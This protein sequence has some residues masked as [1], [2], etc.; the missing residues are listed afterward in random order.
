MGTG[1]GLW[2][3]EMIFID[4]DA[5]P[6]KS[7]MKKLTDQP[8]SRRKFIQ[9]SGALFGASL[10]MQHY[11]GKVMAE[12]VSAH[13]IKVNAHLWVYASKYPPKWDSTPDLESVFSDMH[14]AGIDGVE[15]MDINLRHDNA[16][17]NLSTL[18]QKYHLPVSGT[19]YG[20]NMWDRNEHKAILEDV[21]IIVTRLHQLK[22]KTFGISVGDARHLKT[23]DELDAQASLLKQIIAICND[24]GIEANLHNHTYEVENAMHDLKGTLARIPGIKLGPD[25]NWLIRAGINPVDFINTY[26]NQMVYMHLRDQYADG[27]WTEYLSQGVTDFTAIAQALKA[28]NF[29]GNAAIELA[30]PAGFTPVNPLKE[31]WKKS[32]DYVRHVFGW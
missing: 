30:F 29:K 27:S 15:L 6:F 26:G 5:S 23:E 4:N 31:D 22:G 25:L 21:T 7:H 11:F 8:S 3:Y 19:S 12:A 17:Q 10:L 28:Q 2:P 18:I 16:V 14:Y 24:N 13:K 9:Q 1:C 20:A 32:R